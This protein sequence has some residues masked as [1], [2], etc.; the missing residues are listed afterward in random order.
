[1]SACHFELSVGKPLMEAARAVAARMEPALN[2]SHSF[3]VF[4]DLILE[5]V[6]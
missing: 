3:C 1:M 5:A 4:R 2:R 6:A